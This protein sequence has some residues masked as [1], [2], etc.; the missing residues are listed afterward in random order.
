VKAI[1]QQYTTPF[2]Q[3]VADTC[4]AS[5]R[6]SP[7]HQPWGRG[8]IIGT[9]ESSNIWKIFSLHEPLPQA[10]AI[11]WVQLLGDSFS[12][13]PI[14]NPSHKTDTDEAFQCIHDWSFSTTSING[15][16][17]FADV[18]MASVLI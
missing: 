3:N 15:S 18:E 14:N 13:W 4:Y 17:A 5:S 11:S 6:S 12:A 2:Y 8:I 10:N 1:T 7:E 9:M 16:I